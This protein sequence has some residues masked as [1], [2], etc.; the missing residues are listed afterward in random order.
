MKQIATIAILATA[1][2]GMLS[3]AANATWCTSE[4]VSKWM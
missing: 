4:P 2:T 3:T 1:A